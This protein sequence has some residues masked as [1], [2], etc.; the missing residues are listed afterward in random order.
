MAQGSSYYFVGQSISSQGGSFINPT[1]INPSFTGQM[2]GADGTAALPAYSFTADPDTGIYRVGANQL[3]FSTNGVNR[4]TL[5]DTLATFAGAVVIPV[6]A[7]GTPSLYFAGSATTGLYQPAADRIGLAAQGVTMFQVKRDPTFA[8]FANAAINMAPTTNV[9]L[10]LRVD[11]SNGVDGIVQYR[12]NGTTPNFRVAFN[13]IVVAYN[14]IQSNLNGSVGAPAYSVGASSTNTGLYAPVDGQFA[15]TS[16][17][18]QSALLA[19]T[20]WSNWKWATAAKTTAYTVLAAD[21]G[22]SLDNAAAGASVTFTLPASAIG[23]QYTFFNQNANGIVLDAVGSDIIRF[24]GSDSTAGGTQT[25]TT[26]G[27]S[28]TIKC[29]TVGIWNS[30]GGVGGTWAAA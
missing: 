21:S 6:G 5:S 11:E 20:R 8:T 30:V 4:L 2:F 18:T 19:S 14:A 26:I 7:V 16:V 23:L 28:V 15:V 24:P 27:A 9:A 25:T 3:G 22:T 13:G 12:A 29:N 10:S 17:G 1:F